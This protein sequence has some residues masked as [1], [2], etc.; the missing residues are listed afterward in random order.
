LAARED[1]VIDGIIAAMRLTRQSQSCTVGSRLFLHR[2]IFDSF[3]WQESI[4]EAL[5]AAR[6]QGDRVRIFAAMRMSAY[7]GGFNWSLQHRA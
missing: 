4:P 6:R 1:W 7:G 2:D 5:L 3:L